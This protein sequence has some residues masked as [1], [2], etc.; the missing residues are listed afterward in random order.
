MTRYQRTVLGVACAIFLAMGFLTSALGPMMPELAA[1]TGST[2]G[3]LGAAFTALFLGGLVSQAAAGML[4]E[5]WG[6]KPIVMCGV[7]LLAIGAL[8]ILFSRSLA[9]VLTAAGI[10][11]LGLGMVEVIVNVQ[12]A[13]AFSGSRNVSALNLLHLFFGVGAG[14]GPAIAGQIWRYWGS[15]LPVLVVAAALLLLVLIPI[16]RMEMRRSGSIA[17]RPA[18]G[19]GNPYGSFLLWMF[20]LF[21]LAYVGI[22]TGMGGW[23]ATYMQQTTSMVADSAAG[24]ASGFWLALTVGRLV[25]AAMGMR[26]NSY[27]MLSICLS[28]ALLSGLLLAGST[29]AQS[30]TVVAVLG[31]GFSFGAIYPTVMAVVMADF[32][33]VAGKAVGFSGGLGSIGGMLLPWIQGLLLEQ[34][35]PAASVQF[36]AAGCVAMVL[37]YAGIWWQGRKK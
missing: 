19:E 32:P 20:G 6:Q 4:V 5:R 2:L 13:E 17:G 26:L 27:Q 33:A 29:G 11:G 28:G 22:E 36:S 12:V 7:V 8:G 31:M 25:G 15:G 23:I 10:G 1:Q 35:G 9:A 18:Q 34:F 30:L 24:V 14:T 21:L 37:L 3:A 16:S